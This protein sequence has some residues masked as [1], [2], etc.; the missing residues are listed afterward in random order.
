MARR[1]WVPQPG[2]HQPLHGGITGIH[3]QIPPITRLENDPRVVL[4]ENVLPNPMP[5]RMGHTG[6]RI[7]QQRRHQRQFKLASMT[8]DV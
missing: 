5:P 1:L 4:G 2:G 8:R 6:G 3:G 7:A